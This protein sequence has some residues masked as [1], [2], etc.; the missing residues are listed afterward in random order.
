MGIRATTRSTH[1]IDRIHFTGDR[2]T[3]ISTR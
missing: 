2:S 3:V 1:S